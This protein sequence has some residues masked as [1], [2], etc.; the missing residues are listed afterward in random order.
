MCDQEELLLETIDGTISEIS[1]AIDEKND[2]A[3]ELG[4]TLALVDKLKA[5]VN[6]LSETSDQ[7]QVAKLK[8]HG[9]FLLDKL[10]ACSTDS[11]FDHEEL[12][13]GFA[14]LVEAKQTK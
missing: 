3:S 12:E 7:E 11:L 6:E 4:D 1:M 14:D 10:T 13:E 2:A 5:V 8:D 9:G